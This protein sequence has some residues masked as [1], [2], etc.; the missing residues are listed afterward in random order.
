METSSASR[1]HPESSNNGSLETSAGAS[2]SITFLQ[3]FLK[4]EHELCGDRR[5]HIYG[6]GYSLWKVFF[7][8]V[9]VLRCHSLVSKLHQNVIFHLPRGVILQ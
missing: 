8:L 6:C 3:E 5:N 2:A 9:Q 1:D 7:L 4:K